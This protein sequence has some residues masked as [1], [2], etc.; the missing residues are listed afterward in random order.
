MLASIKILVTKYKHLIPFFVA[1]WITEMVG[2]RVENYFLIKQFPTIEFHVINSIASA[3]SF[4]AQWTL[5]PFVIFVFLVCSLELAKQK[6]YSIPIAIITVFAINALLD[7]IG[8]ASP[9]FGYKNLLWVA[10]A[11]HLITIV[12]VAYTLHKQKDNRWLGYIA[13]YLIG[14]VYS[15]IMFNVMKIIHQYHGNFFNK[16]Q[17]R[18]IGYAILFAIVYG[19]FTLIKKKLSNRASSVQ[20]NQI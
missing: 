2:N 10:Y 1:F 17:F 8:F 4:F 5:Y 15:A 16:Q 3:I 13:Y 20:Q 7:L 14:F 19:L 12:S 11:I 18:A 6:A 9:Y